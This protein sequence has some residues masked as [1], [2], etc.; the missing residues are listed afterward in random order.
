[1][2]DHE[3]VDQHMTGHTGASIVRTVLRQ[4]RLL[5][6]AGIATGVIVVGIGSRLAMLL[7]RL[8]SP[9]FVI[10]MQSDDRCGGPR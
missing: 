10:G 2:T 5:I 1:M 6:V 9:D 4:L 8:T 7:L 3:L